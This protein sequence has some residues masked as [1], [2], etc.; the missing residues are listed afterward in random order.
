MDP[1]MLIA[2][3]TMDCGEVEVYTHGQREHLISRRNHRVQTHIRPILRRLHQT[4]KSFL[5]GLMNFRQIAKKLGLVQG[6]ARSLRARLI[7]LRGW[8]SLLRG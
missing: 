1:V 7:L 8:P 3:D 6:M 5:Q 2:I 4:L